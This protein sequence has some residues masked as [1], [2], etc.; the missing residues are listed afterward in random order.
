[1]CG[2][3]DVHR[4]QPYPAQPMLVRHQPSKIRGSAYMVNDNPEGCAN[5]QENHF[6][7]VRYRMKLKKWH[8]DK[9]PDNKKEAEEKS[10]EIVEAY[11]VLS[12]RAFSDHGKHKS[13]RR[14]E[15][16]HTEP[17]EPCSQDAKSIL[18]HGK[19][20]C[21]EYDDSTFESDSGLSCS[22]DNSSSESEE[23]PSEPSSETSSKSTP[24]PSQQNSD[25]ESWSNED[26]PEPNKSLP[27]HVCKKPHE[28]SQIEEHEPSPNAKDCQVTHKRLSGRNR[29]QTKGKCLP[30]VRSELHVK[31]RKS[32][33]D[34]LLQKSGEF[35]WKRKEQT[36]RNESHAERSEQQTANCECQTRRPKLPKLKT[37]PHI[38]EGN[39]PTGKKKQK[40]V[41]CEQHTENKI[42]K[43][44]ADDLTGKREVPIKKCQAKKSRFHQGRGPDVR[45]EA[46]TEQKPQVNKHESSTAFLRYTRKKTASPPQRKEM[47][48]HG[49]AL[50]SPKNEA[51]MGEI[52]SRQRSKLQAGGRTLGVGKKVANVQKKPLHT[53][54]SKMNVLKNEL[55][56]TKTCANAPKKE[57][58]PKKTKM[59]IQKIELHD[60]RGQKTNP[61]LKE[62]AAE[63]NGPAYTWKVPATVWLSPAEETAKLLF[64]GTTEISGA[65]APLPGK[66]RPNG[67][68][69]PLNGIQLANIQAWNRINQLHLRKNLLPH[70]DAPTQNGKTWP[71]PYI[72]SNHE[73]FKPE[74][75]F[76][77][78]RCS[79]CWCKF[80]NHSP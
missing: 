36:G 41:K 13:N 1:M 76:S 26:T 7:T 51:K 63:G 5:N 37:K 66:L 40:I 67:P 69:Q 4:L 33:E 43:V 30:S 73:M 34:P 70:I 54:R 59:N 23:S 75:L 47:P 60:A 6:D 20:S 14:E 52:R 8:P 61:Q 15:K 3:S 11:K 62:V 38:G 80:L 27:L 2:F 18:A 49:T 44:E 31:D 35:S 58:R 53:E 48:A 39:L 16:S 28:T 56:A 22:E 25:S 71:P 17:N 65:Q 57:L 9:N 79:Q 19:S 12:D 42:E 74:A 29:Q 46:L 72:P 10:K 64:G 24:E 21:S 68:H 55:H 77:C 45:S 50:E 32:R 78:P